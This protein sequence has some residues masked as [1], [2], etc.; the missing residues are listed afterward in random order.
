MTAGAFGYHGGDG[1]GS[2]VTPGP[3]SG[4]GFISGN[5]Y[6]IFRAATP[7]AATNTRG[8]IFFVPITVGKT[9]TFSA[10]GVQVVAIDATTVWRL[11]LYSDSGTAKPLSLLHDFGTVSGAAI[12]FPIITITLTL[13]PGR[14]WLCVV[15]QGPA[16]AGNPKILGWGE[17][18]AYLVQVFGSPTGPTSAGGT[19]CAWQTTAHTHLGALPATPGILVQSTTCQAG[20]VLRAA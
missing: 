15:R 7:P 4:Y 6:P 9:R 13:A 10:V 12:G 11:G 14:S 18:T 19:Q 2:E 5:Y 17:S 1:T 16:G 3:S 20:V 8:R